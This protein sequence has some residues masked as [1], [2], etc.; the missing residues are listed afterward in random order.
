[1]NLKSSGFSVPAVCEV[2][3]RLLQVMRL[4]GEDYFLE[5][6]ELELDRLGETPGPQLWYPQG[7]WQVLL[8]LSRS[9]FARAGAYS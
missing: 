5:D 1:M 7:S 3:L 9:A 6:T 2:V 8:P 4:V